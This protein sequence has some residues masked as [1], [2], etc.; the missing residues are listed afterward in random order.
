M[1]EKDNELRKLFAG[2]KIKA[3]AKLK[4]RIMRQIETESVLYGKKVKTKPAVPL[5][6]H[7][8]AV[9][10]V[11]YA[12]IAAIAAGIHF[13]GRS[14]WSATFLFAALFVAAVCGLFL[15]I[16]VFDDRQRRRNSSE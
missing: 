6:K 13:G 1:D 9:W 2:A 7:M 10:G 12:V 5:I 14:L 4:Y 11:M 8:I 3:G 15:L 16:S